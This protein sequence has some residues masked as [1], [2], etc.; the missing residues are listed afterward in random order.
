MLESWD[1]APLK[2]VHLGCGSHVIPGFVNVDSR[3]LPGVD[4]V[5]EIGDLSF[6]EDESCEVIYA[7]HVLEHLAT[8]EVAPF[9]ARCRAK[10]APGGRLLVAVPDL[11]AI[12]RHHLADPRVFGPDPKAVVGYLYGGQDYPQNFHRTGF[13]YDILAG[14]LARAGFA[15]ARRFRAEDTGCLD[16]S[17]EASHLG[18]ISLNVE[19]SRGPFAS[20]RVPALYR[21]PLLA[22]LVLSLYHRRFRVERRLR[23][24]LAR[25]LQVLGG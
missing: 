7:S 16:S 23:R 14:E 6:L 2:R 22:R 19:A 4:V 3:A 5:S 11:E 1:M 12:F 8:A 13:T 25:W 9:L 24:R 20:A 21:R 17:L 18:P 10:L 15:E